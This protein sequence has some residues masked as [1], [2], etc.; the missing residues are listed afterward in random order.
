MSHDVADMSRDTFSSNR[1]ER[2]LEGPE[3]GVKPYVREDRVG[4]QTWS[5]RETSRVSSEG[6]YRTQQRIIMR[7]DGNRLGNM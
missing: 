4:N 5:G 2:I 1:R 3:K 6:G 7:V